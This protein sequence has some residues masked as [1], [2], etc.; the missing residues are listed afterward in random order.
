MSL[1]Y[2]WI[3]AIALIIIIFVFGVV[4]D[5][6]ITS[7]QDNLPE[8][9]FI[10]SAFT[11]VEFNAMSEPSST[12]NIVLRNDVGRRINVSNITNSN[13]IQLVGNNVNCNLLVPIQP[14]PSQVNASGSFN[15][16]FQCDSGTT[17]PDDEML[18][19]SYELKYIIDEEGYFDKF[20]DSSVVVRSVSNS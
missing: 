2:L 11:C 16:T 6:G 15:L 8:R 14:I 20:V 12:I 9:C 5:F 1:E 4:V 3:Y 13:Q 18:K 19:L 7:P 17:I 10:E